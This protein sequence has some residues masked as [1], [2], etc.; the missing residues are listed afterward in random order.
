MNP[1][2]IRQAVLLAAGRGSRMGGQTDAQPKCLL[3]L[4]GRPLLEWTLRA[5]RSNGIE[6][7]LIITGWQSQCLAHWSKHLRHNPGWAGGNMVR[8]LQVADDWLRRAPTLVVYGDGAYG[9]SAL[10]SALQANDADLVVPVDTRWLELWCR[11]FANPLDDAETLHRRGGYLSRIGQRPGSLGDIQGQFMGLLRTTP[12]SWQRITARLDALELVQGRAAVD[13][14][15]M[16]GLLQ[17][18]LDAGERIACVEVAGGWVEID[19]PQDALAV[20]TALCEPAFS[21]DFRA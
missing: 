2:N 9:T 10:Q 3:P 16:T 17:S 12:A 11:R 7:V 13:R 15:D 18:L 14:L 6:D 21:H 20:E 4:A 8:S 19:S 5:L 1:T